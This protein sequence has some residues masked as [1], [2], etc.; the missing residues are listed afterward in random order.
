MYKIPDNFKSLRSPHGS[1]IPRQHRL[2][3]ETHAWLSANRDWLE[4]EVHSLPSQRP[5]PMHAPG[6][7]DEL[8]P[9]KRPGQ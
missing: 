3:A 8:V 2:T 6:R 1:R 9:L 5:V 7:I 4:N